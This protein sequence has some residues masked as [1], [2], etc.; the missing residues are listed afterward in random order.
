MPV[1]V[2]LQPFFNFFLNFGVLREFCSGGSGLPPCQLIHCPPRMKAPR[3]AAQGPRN[4]AQAKAGKGPP[5]VSTSPSQPTR[6]LLFQRLR[7]LGF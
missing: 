5:T 7:E 1:L 4:R 3:G 2:T 6:P